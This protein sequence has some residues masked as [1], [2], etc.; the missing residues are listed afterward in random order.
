[1]KIDRLTRVNVL[2]RREIGVSLY[3]IMN[4]KRFDLA[5]VTVTH[6][7]TSSDLRS[8]RV[9]VSIRDP[10][11][12]HRGEMLALLEKHRPDIQRQIADNVILKYTPRL[13]FELDMSI[14]EGDRVLSLLS[15][16]EPPAPP[17]G[18][19]PESPQP[20]QGTPHDV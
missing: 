12:K 8:A 2:L 1:M 14:E 19:P 17:P 15:K 7:I 9:L 10:D 11:P 6:V 20:E 4:E 5:A 13:S 3:R 18:A 16:L